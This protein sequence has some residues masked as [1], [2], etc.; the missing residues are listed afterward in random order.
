MSHS[1]SGYASMQ[2]KTY[3]S[4]SPG[5]Q[6][7]IFA[8]FY[9]ESGADI[10]GWHIEAKS[11][12]FSAAFFMVENFYAPHPP[13]V[14]RSLQDDMYAPWTIDYPPT[15]GKLRCPVPEFASHVLESMQ[16]RFVEEWLFFE[17]DDCIDAE[18]TACLA[19]G[20]PIHEVNI[21]SR[22]LPRFHKDGAAWTYMTPGIDLNIVQ[23]L[24]KY[25]RLCEK[26]PAN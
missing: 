15:R 10:Y 14:Y 2:P 3:I 5:K 8:L 6:G 16:S 18:R 1:V 12:Y 25:W 7:A 20:L 22:K 9:I 13:R 11:Q 26:V 17:S 21:K 4:Y 23:T 24:K 19:R